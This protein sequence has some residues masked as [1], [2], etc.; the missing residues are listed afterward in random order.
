MTGTEVIRVW[1]A[2]YLKEMWGNI[3]K[4]GS[5]ALWCDGLIDDESDKPSIFGK[6][7]SF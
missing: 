4:S 1:T 6:S 2:E 5:T 7:G 3:K